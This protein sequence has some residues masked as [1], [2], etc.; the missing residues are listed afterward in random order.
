MHR[1]TVVVGTITTVAKGGV[2]ILS[3]RAYPNISKDAA[4]MIIFSISFGVSS[5]TSMFED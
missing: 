2:F 1:H 5:K 3:K 4:N